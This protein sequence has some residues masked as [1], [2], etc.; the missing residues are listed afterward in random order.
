MSEDDSRMTALDERL[1]RLMS[2]L[3]ARDGFEARLHARIAASPAREDLRAQIEAG[4]AAVRRRLR[5]EAWANGITVAGAGIGL[6]V[7]V[8][9]WA[10]EIARLASGFAIP[11]DPLV[12]AGITVAAVAPGLWPL[13]RQVP[14][15]RLG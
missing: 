6:G 11:V 1:R 10:P 2:G 14:G 9:H 8:W 5:R 7:L 13:L 12:I 4:R 3:D 15:L